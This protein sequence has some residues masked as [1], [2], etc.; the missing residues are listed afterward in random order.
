MSLRVA[1]AGVG[2]MLPS[3][4]PFRLGAPPLVRGARL[5]EELGFDSGWVGDHL[6]FHPP[7]LDA[8]CALSAAAACTERLVLGAGGLLLPLRGPV[9]TAKQ[10]ATVASPAPGRVLLGAGV[11]GVDPAEFEAAGVPR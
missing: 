8:L 2:V 6:S 10:V 5:A 7:V 1:D 4:G 11:G 3:F 9:W